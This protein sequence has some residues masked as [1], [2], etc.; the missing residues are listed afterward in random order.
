MFR[1]Q[2][3]HLNDLRLTSR[4]EVEHE[5]ISH[6]AS[7]PKEFYKRVFYKLLEMELD[8]GKQ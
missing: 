4:E 5:W 2:Q 6:F 8:S 1:G 7:K 3:N